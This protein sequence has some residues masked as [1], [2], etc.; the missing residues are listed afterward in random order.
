[1]IGKPNKAL[2]RDTPQA[3]FAHL[4]RVPELARLGTLGER[5]G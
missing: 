1:M 5:D 2:Q 4:L 3:G